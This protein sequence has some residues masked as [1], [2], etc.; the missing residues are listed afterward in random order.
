VRRPRAGNPGYSM[1]SPIVFGV[2]NNTGSRVS[3]IIGGLKIPSPL[4]VFEKQSNLMAGSPLSTCPSNGTVASAAQVLFG[5]DVSSSCILSLT[6]EQLKE[7][8]CQG[9][10]VCTAGASDYSDASGLPY[11]FA[12]SPEGASYSLVGSVG[13][14]GNADPLDI[15]QWQS[16]EVTSTLQPSARSWDDEKGTCSN[17]YSS[18]NIEFL[19]AKT[20]TLI[21]LLIS[22]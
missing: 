16:L 11:M 9:S 3:E 21:L 20:C 13:T 6:R 19:I 10:T 1:G 22:Y 12:T 7:M 2:A 5:Y 14:Y 18:M 17:M 4:A 15:T 8:C